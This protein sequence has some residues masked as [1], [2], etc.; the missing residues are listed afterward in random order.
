[1]NRSWLKLLL[2][3]LLLALATR[4]GSSS[5]R[6]VDSSR[7]P[8]FQ[9]LDF[10]PAPAP[11]TTGLLSG[12]GYSYVYFD[13]VTYGG[14]VWAADSNRWEALRGSGANTRCWTFD[15]GV[16]SN[17]TEPTQVPKPPGYHHRMEG[18][19][20]I[21]FTFS[22][23]PWFRRTTTCAI[24]GQF[25]LWSG[26]T[27]AEAESLCYAGGQGYGENWNITMARTFDYPGA[28]NVTFGYAYRVESEPGFDYLY[29]KIDTTGIGAAADLE[30]AVY[31]GTLTGTAGHTLIPGTTLRSTPGP[32]IIKFQATSDG[33]YS[34]QDGAYPTTC[35]HSAIDD[36]TLSGAVVHGAS[37]ESGD[38]G[39]DRVDPISGPGGEWSHLRH[40]STLPP[41]LSFCPCALADSVL[42]FAD[43]TGGHQTRV[44]NFAASP[45]C[46]LRA[47]GDVGKPGKLVIFHAWADLPLTNYLFLNTLI[48]YYPEVCILTGKL[49]TTPFRSFD[50]LSFPDV[51]P[52]CTA[53]GAP[54][55]R[56]MSQQVS[57]AAEKIRIGLGVLSYC[58]LFANC[59]GVSNST[60][61]FDNVSLGVYG[62]PFAPIVSLRT[63]DV[64]QD[65][66]SRDGT[67]NPAA[68]GRIDCNNV[69]GAASPAP[70]TALGD[71]LVIG[72][73]G[74]NQEVRIVF[75]VRPGPFTNLPAL[76]AWA[77]DKWS[78]NGQAAPG[79]FQNSW[80]EARCDTAE[81]GNAISSPRSW[82]STLHESDPRFGGGTDRD[83]GAEGDANQLSHDIFPDNIL[84]PGSRIDY[85]VKARYLPPDPRNPSGTYQFLTPDTTGGRYLEVEI[86]PSSMTADTSWNCTLHVD[87]RADRDSQAQYLAEAGLTTALGSG[88]AN[89]EGTRFDRYDVQ[90][91]SSQQ[92]SLGRPLNTQY[93]ASAMQLFA[94]KQ[95]VWHS[96]NLASFNLVDE[97]ANILSAWLTIA[98]VGGNRFWGSG[99][100]LVRAMSGEGEPTTQNF[101]T[102]LCGVRFTCDTIRISGCPAGSVL[103]STF[104]LPLSGVAGADFMTTTPTWVRGNGCPN[105]RSFDLLNANPA[106]ATAKGQLTYVKS[107]SPVAAPNVMSVTN[108]NT[109]GVDYMTV[110]DGA[111][112][113]Y[114]RDPNGNPHTLAR[115]DITTPSIQRTVDVLNWFA[116]MGPLGPCRLS[117]LFTGVEPPPGGGASIYRTQ[118]LPAH[119]NPM[120]G[121]TRLRF[122]LGSSGRASLRLFDVTG[123]LVRTLHD[124][125]LPAGPQELQWDG[126]GEDGRNVSAGLYFVRLATRDE[127][128]SI[129]VIVRD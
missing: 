29:V 16:G 87:H 18:W 49:Y 82:M 31:D 108:H 124:A 71:T 106:V 30:L 33:A 44:D 34:D 47:S 24:N 97:D 20:G 68:P 76:A 9:Q 94:Y 5:A 51:I 95:V 12:G 127:V 59:T 4:P 10:D 60:P 128:Q 104:C 78:Y 102:S 80:F 64:F 14:T 55:V 65:N 61:W 123:R 75:R 81:Q 126:R 52:R 50:G 42:L 32:V 23:L 100:G 103:D 112:V 2:L 22:T 74:G 69:K 17:F 19:K 41:P 79:Y 73:D 92:A 116:S 86:L 118:L 57:R 25:S 111:E 48:S 46:D 96:G 8:R 77:A 109:T 7:L 28:G 105:L 58:N 45:W 40:I 98:E 122:T 120:S 129:K 113:G 117:T 89:A 6:P 63:L 119:P 56:N 84:T 90:A 67:L 121:T 54:F 26:V 110:I 83:R 43:L 3:P 91:P 15:T 13:T 125:P 11:H 38:D 72:G 107:G 62:A 53:P 37:F 1:M 39:W 66:F 70:N 88:S 114:L 36:I 115:C 93:G 35:G 99:D 85:F 101:L 27:L 21:D